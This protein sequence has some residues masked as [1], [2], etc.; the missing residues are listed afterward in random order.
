MELKES[1]NMEEIEKKKP[2]FIPFIV[3]IIVFG[4]SFFGVKTLFNNSFSFDQAM[5]KVASELNKSC[6]IMVDRETRLDNV[7]AMPENV[8]QYNYTLINLEKSEINIEEL[9]EYIE[10]NVV[11]NV[12]TN[13]DMKDYRENKVTMAYNYRDKN[14]VFI[15]RINVTP[16]MYE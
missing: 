11:N 1:V 7:A 8:F 16:E 15:L 3:G 2:K 9:R 12:K 4:I 13:P 10:P 6:P 14:G 5:V